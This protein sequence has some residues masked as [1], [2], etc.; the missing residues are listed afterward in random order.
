MDTSPAGQYKGFD[1][2]PLAYQHERTAR[3]PEAREDRS[4]NAAVMICRAGESPEP[5]Q[6][7][8][9][10]LSGDQQFG[11]VGDARVAALRFAESIIDGDVPD[12]SLSMGGA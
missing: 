6:T 8:V 3:W 7:Q 12:L 5:G 11:N 4:Y 1:I 10:R 9:F 2:Y